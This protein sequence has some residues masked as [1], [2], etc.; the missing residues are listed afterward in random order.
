M[1]EDLSRR[2]RTPSLLVP[3]RVLGDTNLAFTAALIEPDTEEILVLCR[4]RGEPDFIDMWQYRLLILDVHFLFFT[5]AVNF[6]VAELSNL[7]DAAFLFF[8]KR[9]MFHQVL[10][11]EKD[12]PDG[13]KN[14]LLFFCAISLIFFEDRLKCREYR[15]I[16]GK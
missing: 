5:V 12:K 7:H 2:L 11:G 16:F 1:E 15:F 8:L 14:M 9:N 6:L 10:Q 13:F 3:K 4:T